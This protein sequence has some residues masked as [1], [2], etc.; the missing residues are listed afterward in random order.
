MKK[1]VTCSTEV[2]AGGLTP[3]FTIEYLK[4]QALVSPIK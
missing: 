2:E 4:T 3:K 1:V